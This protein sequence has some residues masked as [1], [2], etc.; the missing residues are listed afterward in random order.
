MTVRSSSST[1]E[2]RQ[3]AFQSTLWSQV[4]VAGEDEAPGATQALEALCRL[5]WHPI[6]AFLRRCGHEREDAMDLTQGFFGYLL[7][8]RLLS[9]ANPAKGRFR[10]FLLG[11]LKNFASNQQGHTRARKRGGGVLHVP[12]AELE[13]AET[14]L[15]G[16][17]GQAAPDRLFERKWA[18]TVIAEAINRLAAEYRRAG[19]GDQFDLLRPYLTGEAERQVAELAAALGKSAGA[20]RILLFR[21]RNRLRRLIRAVLAETV[22]E[23]E[24]VDDELRHV[25]EALRVD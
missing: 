2:L 19:L 8:E 21:A 23:P 1:P 9:K 25:A 22:S 20:V 13:E 12:L 24:L 17:S 5:Y 16:P 15:R 6:Y 18:L 3:V 7:E 14:Q 11:A 10:S 4:R